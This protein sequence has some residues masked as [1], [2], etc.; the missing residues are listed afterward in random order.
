M[1]GTNSAASIEK[2][3]MQLNGV[4]S[5]TVS[6]MLTKADVIY[7]RDKISAVQIQDAIRDLGYLS[8]IIEE[9]ANQNSKLNLLIGGMSCASC[10]NTI[11]T[12]VKALKGV[13][14]CIVA[15][16]TSTGTVEFSPT[17]VGPRDIIEQ[18]QDLGYSAEFAT[19]EDRLKKLDYEEDIKKWRTSFLI[20]L[21]F[22]IPVMLIMIYFHWIRMSTMSPENQIPVFIKPLSLDNVLLFFVATPVQ[23]FGGRYFYA[24][25]WKAIRQCTLN[26][27]VLVVLATSIAYLYSVVVI[28]IAV[29]LRWNFSP[30]TFFDVPPMLMVFIALGRWLEYKAKSKTSDALSKLMSLQAKEACL[31]TK[32]KNG[33]ITSERGI[34]VELIQRGD[35]IKVFPGEKIAVD[36]ILVEGSSSA[37]ESFI[38]GESMP[39]VK[40][41]GD[42]VIG[43]SVNQHGLIIIKATHVGQDSTLA[44]I[45]RLVE[46]AQTSK[47]PLQQTAD[48]LAGYFVPFVISISIITLITWTLIGV[49]GRS[50]QSNPINWEEVLRVSFEYA[51]TVLSIA[52]PCALGLA[53]PTAIMVGTGVGAKNGVLIKGGEPLEV[54]Q[55]IRTVVFDKTGTITEGKPRVVKI[56]LNVTQAQLSLKNICAIAGTAESNSEH[57]LGDAIVSFAKEYLINDQWSTVSDFIMTPGK[58][59]SCTVS[60]LRNTISTSKGVEETNGF[61]RTTSL[62]L[63]SYNVEVVPLSPGN[64]ITQPEIREAED[65]NNLDAYSVVIGNEKWLLAN[66]I[67]IDAHITNTL[68]NECQA[69]T[70][71]ILIAI[72]RK[73]VAIMGIVDQVKADAALTVWAL[74]KMG[75]KV[76]L[77]TGDNSRTAEAT[78]KKVGITEV[79][80]EVLPNQKKDKINQL[81]E[82]GLK[83]AMVGDG[84]NDSPALATA[85]V[86]IAIATGSDVA[87]ES[88]GIVLVQ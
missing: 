46:D 54:A 76:T 64:M 42:P 20:S 50:N 48:K 77:L 3:V 84:V 52:C 7:D 68:A 40:K 87:I 86:G 22:G 25:S 47:A 45:V 78:A 59:I 28:V 85:N 83:V 16:S 65:W 37:D 82:R 70:I 18:I 66:E 29:L 21:I 19:K 10:V 2:H 41:P 63:P 4:K 24:Q 75:I 79:F 55:K 14:N 5:V 27:D 1:T 60:K 35:L 13:A 33:H 49:Y 9:N 58:G 56:Y 62:Q 31:I 23:F 71:S 34:D 74:H 43:G 67:P 73:V 6:V 69:G 81:Q 12:H 51:I 17:I 88:A 38:T 53:T 8:Q 26:M 30:M 72:N 11:E 39:V 61:A 15:L 80:A 32:D 57:P 44:Q 36:G